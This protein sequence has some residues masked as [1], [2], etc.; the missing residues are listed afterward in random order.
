MD[1]NTMYLNADYLNKQYAN[2]FNT[3]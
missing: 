1:K 2:G 3:S